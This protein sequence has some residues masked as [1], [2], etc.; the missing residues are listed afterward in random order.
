MIV[1]KLAFA[2]VCLAPIISA[3]DAKI[4]R[5]DTRLVEVEVVVR[6][7]K[8]PIRG[9]KQE[10]F[11]L[12]DNGKPQKI[13]TFSVVTSKGSGSSGAAAPI[14]HGAGQQAELPVTATVLF[15]NNLA[16]A[17]GDQVQAEKRLAEV[18]HKLPP[19][20]PIAVY[21]LNQKLRI[22]TDFTD[23]PVKIAK[24]LE[25]AWGEQPQPPGYTGVPYAYPAL[26][27]IAKELESLPGRKNLLWFAYFFPVFTGQQIPGCLL[28]NASDY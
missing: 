11:Q 8:G 1:C 12:F 6:D 3:Q 7:A 19:L 17:F 10:D 18:F 4:F 14:D 9:L 28:C 2:W 16:I 27:K 25:D 13:G 22:L 26:E 15:I 24:A 21:V 23:D 5:S 20:E